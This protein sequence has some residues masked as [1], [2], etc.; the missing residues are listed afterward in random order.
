MEKC[1]RKWMKTFEFWIGFQWNSCVLKWWYIN[2]LVQERRNSIA[3]AL[4]V[5]LSCTKPSIWELVQALTTP[6]SHGHL[7]TGTQVPWQYFHK[8]YQNSHQSQLNEIQQFQVSEFSTPF[9]PILI[10]SYRLRIKMNWV[11]TNPSYQ[12]LL[13]KFQPFAT[14]FLSLFLQ[15][16]CGFP[17]A[18]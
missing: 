17:C 6:N 4:E 10:C 3:N 1:E 12:L 5:R 11:W 2:G 18:E 7:P 13:C 9:T 16:L 14:T 8:C 15:V